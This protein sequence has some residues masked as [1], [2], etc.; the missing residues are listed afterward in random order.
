MKAGSCSAVLVSECIWL[1]IKPDPWNFKGLWKKTLLKIR[2]LHWPRVRFPP[3]QQLMWQ[4]ERGANHQG[5]ER[6]QRVSINGMETHMQATWTLCHQQQGRA[7]KHDIYHVVDSFES[8][9]FPCW[10]SLFTLHHYSFPLTQRAHQKVGSIS[11]GPQQTEELWN[12]RKFVAPQ[13]QMVHTLR[14]WK[15][16]VHPA[17]HTWIS[18][19]T[20]ACL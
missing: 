3:F 9:S 1:T 2:L 11:C 4:G 6:L 16:T 12:R 10:H 8:L 13:P 19:S 17:Q 15:K 5:K 7:I 14:F 18:N 20:F